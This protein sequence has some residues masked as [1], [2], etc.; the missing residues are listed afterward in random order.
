[1]NKTKSHKGLYV[2]GFLAL[3]GIGGLG[4]SMWHQNGRLQTLETMMKEI[5][6]RVHVQ[7]IVGN[8][9]PEQFYII[10]GDTTY[11]TVDGVPAKEYYP[12]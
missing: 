6:P 1:M 2:L 5:S 9:I 12:K 3:A 8:D 10:D 11:I 7:N 4:A